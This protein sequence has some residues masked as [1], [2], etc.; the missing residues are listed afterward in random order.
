[1]DYQKKIKAISKKLRQISDLKQQQKSGKTLEQSQLE[2]LK[3]ESQLVAEL[4][5]LELE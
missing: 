2:K 1:V 4:K 3:T 5:A